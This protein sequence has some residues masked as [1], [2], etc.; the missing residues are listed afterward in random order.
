MAMSV[1]SD[2]P[3]SSVPVS[4]ASSCV[5]DIPDLEKPV[6]PLDDQPH[7]MVTC[8]GGQLATVLSGSSRVPAAWARTAVVHSASRISA[9]AR[10]TRPVVFSFPVRG[11]V[12]PAAT[13]D[14]RSARMT[15]APR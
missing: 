11:A 14:G 7:T 12:C 2:R 4:S 13:T 5:D 9:N 3:R 15:T 10:V 8:S 1:C 6:Q